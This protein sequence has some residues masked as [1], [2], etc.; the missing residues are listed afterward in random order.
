MSKLDGGIDPERPAT[1]PGRL[2]E[3]ILPRER[4]IIPRLTTIIYD[5]PF[6][7]ALLGLI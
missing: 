7:R 3:L 2:R 1:T 4:A 6:D 5:E